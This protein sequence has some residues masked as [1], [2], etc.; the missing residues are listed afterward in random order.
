MTWNILAGSLDRIPQNT[1]QIPL[2]SR[3]P[4]ILRLI[5]T[6]DPTIIA[7]QE[8]EIDTFQVLATKLKTHGY[9]GQ[10]CPRRHVTSAA[11][12]ASQTPFGQAIFWKNALLWHVQSA[13]IPLRVYSTAPQVLQI[14]Q[15]V[16][17]WGGQY[18]IANVH[19]SPRLNSD[20]QY[21]Q[22]RMAVSIIDALGLIG[23]RQKPNAQVIFC[24]DFNSTPN[25]QACVYLQNIFQGVGD[26]DSAWTNIFRDNSLHTIDY[27]LTLDKKNWRR[28]DS[29]VPNVPPQQFLSDHRPLICSLTYT[30]ATSEGPWHIFKSTPTYVTVRSLCYF[31]NQTTCRNRDDCTHIH[32]CSKCG[33]KHPFRLHYSLHKANHGLTE[34]K[35]KD[36]GVKNI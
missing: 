3:L 1:N 28:S 10:H 15:L 9:R 25:S 23:P 20:I 6:N 2:K 5:V 32:R 7:L 36:T 14:V 4:N 33:E 31:Y 30:Q 35:Q 22:A 27:I 17:R 24:G 8:V 11:V 21:V 16:D 26:L 18:N 34:A 29:S 19:L 13:R 12:Y